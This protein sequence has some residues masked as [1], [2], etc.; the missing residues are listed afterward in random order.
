MR[1]TNCNHEV[2]PVVG[3]DIDGT[4]AQYHLAVTMFASRYFDR[5]APTFPYDGREKFR[6]YLG[7]TQAEHREV[8]VAY[9]QGG[10]KRLLKPYLG[11]V[12]FVANLRALG[13]EVWM[14]TTRPWNR[15]DNI[16]PD[17]QEWLRRNNV[18][19]DGLLYGDDKYEKLMSIVGKDRLIGVIDD[20][21]EQIDMARALGIPAWQ[22][23][24]EHNAHFSTRRT[25]GGSLS[26]ALLWTECRIDEWKRNHE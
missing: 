8:K 11:A 12:D 5:P 1:C 3:L 26:E 19:I 23:H 4:L 16:D 7:L 24:R 22:V 20:L 6:D 15:L 25:P 13:V 18:V 2:L 17:T 10:N 14:A 9:Y 21:S